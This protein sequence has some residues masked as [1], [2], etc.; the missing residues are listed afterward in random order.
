ME[1]EKHFNISSRRAGVMSL[2][3]A[4]RKCVEALR[5]LRRLPVYHR[6]SLLGKGRND[7]EGIRCEYRS[8]IY[9]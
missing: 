5:V 8:Y 4:K 7:E 2:D 9:V 6:P 3:I 1:H